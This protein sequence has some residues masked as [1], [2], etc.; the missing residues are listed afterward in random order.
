M[1]ETKQAIRWQFSGDV[2]VEVLASL[3]SVKQLHIWGLAAAIFG[4]LGGLG[5][6]SRH[7]GLLDVAAKFSDVC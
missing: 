7:G 1:R 6:S 3:S 5:C 4:C 2:A